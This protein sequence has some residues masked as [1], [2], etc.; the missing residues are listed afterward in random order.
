MKVLLINGS[1]NEKGCTYT[2]L[3]EAAD[4]L[5]LCGVETEIVHIGKGPIRGCT[6]CRACAGKGRC[7]FD[8]D[9]VNG[10]AEKFKTCDGLIVGSP[11]Y[12]AS[13]AGGLICLL[14]RMFMCGGGEHKPAAAVVSARRGGTTASLD[15][16]NKYF[17]IRQMPVVSSTYWNMVHGNTPDEVRQDKE[18]MRTIRN[19]ASN[20]AWLL[21]CIECGKENGIIPPEAEKG[22]KTNFIR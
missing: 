2:A 17:M 13:A 4:Q 19:L 8:G 20:M 10:I 15:E 9:A 14:D 16:L 12:F 3:R 22:S 5:E 18:G 11:V 1:P 21:M 6:G 7:V